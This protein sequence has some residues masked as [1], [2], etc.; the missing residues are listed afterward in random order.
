M[1]SL[2]FLLATLASRTFI[3]AAKILLER[4]QIMQTRN[5]IFLEFRKIFATS[6]AFQIKTAHL[7]EIYVLFDAPVFVR[8]AFFHEIH[9]MISAS[10]DVWMIRTKFQLPWQCNY[11]ESSTKF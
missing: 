7:N 8:R 5:I 1:C 9:I 11:T 2:C 4:Y 6:K 3:G 10:G